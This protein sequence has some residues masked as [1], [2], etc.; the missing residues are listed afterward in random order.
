M[1]K[2]EELEKRVSELERLVRRHEEEY[3]KVLFLQEKKLHG[4]PY[5][6][7]LVYTVKMLP[8]PKNDN[9]LQF[10]T[11][12]IPYLSKEEF[13][14]DEFRMLWKSGFVFEKISEANV[15]AAEMNKTLKITKKK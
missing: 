3:E 9:I 15:C 2:V 5:I 14:S 4:F 13:E 8:D 7:D 10:F 12:E 11:V 6:S 1:G